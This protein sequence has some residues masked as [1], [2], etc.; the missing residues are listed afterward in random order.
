MRQEAINRNEQRQEKLARNAHCYSKALN[1]I[2]VIKWEHRSLLQGINGF[3]TTQAQL[4]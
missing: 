2:R 4:I 3:Y 1:T